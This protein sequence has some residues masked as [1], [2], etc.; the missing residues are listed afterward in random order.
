MDAASRGGAARPALIARDL[1]EM[2]GPA[3]PRSA[4][5]RR[6]IDLADGTRVAGDLLPNAT[7]VGRYDLTDSVARFLVRPDADAPV[8]APGQYLALGVPVD[9]RLVQRPYSAARIGDT[10]E[11]LIRHVPGG[12]LTP[13]LWT[14]GVGDRVRLGRPKGRLRLL[15]GDRRAHLFIA[16]GTG[17][18]PF[19][20]MLD[21]LL[22]GD[23][24]ARVVVVHGVSYEAELAY[25]EDLTDRS[26][27][28]P[29]VSYVPVVS[30]PGTAGNAGWAGRT[31][32]ID[33]VLDPVWRDA[34]LATADT[35]AYLCGNPEMVRAVGRRL[36]DRGLAAEA[37]R[38]ETFWGTAAG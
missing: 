22:T 5:G 33:D 35:V 8:V 4:A 15:P 37:V 11:F 34:D 24:D 7:L 27:A 26:R 31:G 1:A 16:T 12:Q 23:P 19:V 21:A 30:R 36:G 38:S 25:R 17:L 13:R 2:L 20:A 32:R 28:H 6:G 10:V 3:V 9:G 18:G 29:G 14:L